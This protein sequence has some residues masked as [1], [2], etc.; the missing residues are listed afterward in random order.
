M[1]EINSTLVAV[2]S[3]DLIL[4]IIDDMMASGIL[5]GGNISYLS[6]S[7]VGSM[8][9]LLSLQRG[10]CHIAPVHLLDEETGTYNIVWAKKILPDKDLGLI[11]GVGRIQGLIVP[12]DNPLDIR[13]INDLCRCRYVNRQR[14]AGTRIFLDYQLKKSGIDPNGIEG[15]DREAATHMA[16]AASVQSGN[17]DVGMGIASAAKALDLGFIPLGEEE[18]DFITFKDF[19]ELKEMKFF[20]DILKSSDFHGKLEELGGYTWSRAGEIVLL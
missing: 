1:E 4:D 6:S 10:E 19:L 2:G 9:G 5:P 8:A 17:A 3:H 18:Y 11:K 12:K 7:H 14:G 20:L 13:S 15:Y 16:V